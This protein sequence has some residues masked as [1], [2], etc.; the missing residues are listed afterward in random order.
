VGYG[1]YLTKLAVDAMDTSIHVGEVRLEGEWSEGVPCNERPMANRDVKV[2]YGHGDME[3]IA[4]G[5]PD[6]SGKFEFPRADLAYQYARSTTL[7]EDRFEVFVDGELLVSAAA[8]RDYFTKNFAADRTAFIDAEVLRASEDATAAI[9]SGDWQDAQAAIETCKAVAP[10]DPRCLEL[11]GVYACE[12]AVRTYEDGGDVETAWK[13]LQATKTRYPQESSTV[14]VEA[15]QTSMAKKY[16]DAVADREAAWEEEM[17]ERAELAQRLEET[18]G[19]FNRVFNEYT[20]ASY[21]GYWE[22]EYP[23]GY[24]D[25][26]EKDAFCEWRSRHIRAF[27]KAT[28]DNAMEHFCLGLAQK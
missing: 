10:E 20:N 14:C 5:T 16:E 15:A 21:Y 11:E 18:D 9:K 4:A 19:S 3:Q 28:F 7:L 26:G 22:M 2:M 8:Q 13:S 25:E 24:L 23:A 1:G 27:D 17:K 12:S 6:E